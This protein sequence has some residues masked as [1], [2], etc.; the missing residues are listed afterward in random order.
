MIYSLEIMR[1]L[2]KR[3]EI[4]FVAYEGGASPESIARA[5]EYSSE[6]Y[7]I[8]DP[9]EER[10]L[11]PY[12]LEVGREFV[13]TLPRDAR[14]YRTALMARRVS[15]LLSRHRFDAC[16]CE[17]SYMAA[18]IRDLSRW[19]VM[20]HNVESMLIRRRVSY[21]SARLIRKYF[22]IDS[23]RMAALE[24][25]VCREAAHIIAISDQDAATM[26][27]LYGAERVSPIHAGVDANYFARPPQPGP[28][29][30]AFDLV[31]VGKM[32]WP[33]NVDGAQWF[34]QSVLPLIREQRPECRLALVGQ[35]PEEGII[36]LGQ[37]YPNVTVTG[38]VDDVR[39]WLW[40]ASAAIVPLRIGGGIRIK[41]YEAMAAGTPLV[42]TTI[43]AEGLPVEPS[44]HLLLADDP[45]AF[46]E[47]CLRILNDREAAR[48][49][50][51]RAHLFVR[52][53]VSWDHT[54]REVEELISQNGFR[55]QG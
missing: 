51:A 49:M 2:H 6:V 37:N 3:H 11:R 26:K 35:L 18:N 13:S 54:A 29:W 24:R 12:L 45:R 15:D 21:E 46:A 52:E 5:E 40:G 53:R 4:H 23:R 31:F 36:S 17:F 47:A 34:V 16:V 44:E 19:I 43:G 33:P 1:R 14:H 27:S 9:I 28:D 8:P 25:R 42:S 55:S 30:P 50:A 22:D 32:G 39:P 48:R 38:T 20:Q 7:Q 41:I 10:S